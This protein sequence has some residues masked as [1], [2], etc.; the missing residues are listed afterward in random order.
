MDN[1]PKDSELHAKHDLLR[2][3]NM[4]Y[5]AFE[6]ASD[7]HH[8]K[9]RK[10]FSELKIPNVNEDSFKEL[11]LYA[12]TRGYSID[13][14]AELVEEKIFYKFAAVIKTLN[15]KEYKKYYG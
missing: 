6:K 7:E 5:E 12:A 14:F 2:A 4:P 1:M 8:F 10:F 3:N 15:P 9:R 11:A 13:D